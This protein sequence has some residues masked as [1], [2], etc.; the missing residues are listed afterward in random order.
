MSSSLSS[1]SGV[2]GEEG[3]PGVDVPLELHASEL[4]GTVWPLKVRLA[5]GRSPKVKCV[6]ASPFSSDAGEAGAG[7]G[8]VVS[9]R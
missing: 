2:R 3:E 1:E 7:G 8:E 9:K 5:S 6:G 4:Q